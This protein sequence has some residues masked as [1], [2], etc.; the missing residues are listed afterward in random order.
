MKIFKA[1]AFSLLPI[2]LIGNNGCTIEPAE[3]KVASPSGNLEFILRLKADRSLEYLINAVDS[4]H[5]TAVISESPLGIE[6][7][8][9]QF[10]KNL[11][12]ISEGVSI[13][14]T[15]T[16]DLVSGKRKVTEIRSNM[17]TVSFKNENGAKLEITIRIFDDGAAFR[18][19][20]PEDD[21]A[22]KTV[23]SELTGFSIA[24]ESKSWIHKYDKVT[25]YSPGYETY[26][27]NGT[28]AGE[29]APSDEGWSFPALFESENRWILITE[30]AA[31]ESY[32]AAHLNPECYNRL[33]TVRM[34]E[35]GEA[36]GLYRKEATSGL[37]WI[38]PWRVIITGTG[39]SAIVES[40]TVESL[41]QPSQ[42]DDR[43]WIKPGRAAWSWWSDP[44]S[45]K[46]LA[47]QKKFIDMAADMGWEYCLVDANWDMMTDGS[48][49]DV[50]KY[51]EKKKVG[52]LMWYNS[53]GPHNSVTE[54]PRDIMYDPVKRME[55]FRKLAAWGVRGVKV[56][57]FQSD[58][59]EIIKQYLGILK[60][61]AD[62][63]IMVNFHGCTMQRGWSRTWPNLVSME[64]VRGAECYLFD[65]LFTSLAPTHNATL[66]FTRNAV[67]SMDYTPVA[68]SVARY[69]HLTTTAHELALAVVFESGIIH[70]ADKPE[71]YQVLPPEVKDYL[72]NV[73]S[74]WDD[75]R[76]LDGYPGS[77]CLIA[78]RSG[79]KWFIGGIN[80][81]S[82]E[83][84]LKADLR[85]LI[86][87]GCKITVISD[88]LA[89]SGLTVRQLNR[90]VET[91]DSISLKAYGGFVA[92]IESEQ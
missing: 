21:T 25:M 41:N 74:A 3:W 19:S 29:S 26:Y 89:D 90:V 1:L 40:V 13:P 8:D 87:P 53:G 10:I 39:L 14:Y 56:D 44:P 38:M 51:A 34:P 75:T 59:Q 61:A 7:E 50:V 11:S 36:N 62:N 18:Y 84:L 27:T 70:F 85:S 71:A 72:S 86:P 77:H 57:F 76:L 12:L 78:R 69:P 15:D 17:R 80:G 35:E 22:L 54:R 66:P 32:F 5:S 9:E 46:S 6:R 79:E 37:P 92:I 91:P 52:I 63:R 49:E 31:N 83:I 55:E 82:A 48:I 68:L 73:P 42:I 30:A 20:F 24:K 47:S 88:N 2:F 4:A 23:K 64:A 43:S 45:P 81:T 60:D 58:K 28:P 16:V 67:G 65:S 33:Y